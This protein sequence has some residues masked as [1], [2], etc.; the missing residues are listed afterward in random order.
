M[1]LGNAHDI[2]GNR[3]MR[4]RIHRNQESWVQAA[5]RYCGAVTAVG[6]ITCAARV[7]GFGTPNPTTGSRL[8][9]LGRP[10]VRLWPCLFGYGMAGRALRNVAGLYQLRLW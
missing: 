10:A 3:L 9:R 4:S 7:V 6:G 8:G 2:S 5:Y 1:T